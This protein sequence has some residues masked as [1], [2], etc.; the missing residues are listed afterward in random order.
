M[1]LDTP[2]YKIL[3]ADDDVRARECGHT[4]TDLDAR[5]GYVHLSSRD[6]VADTLRLHYAGH[7]GVQLYQF[8]AERLNG[9][10]KW[11]KSRGGDLFPHLYGTLRLSDAEKQWTLD[12]DDHGNPVLP[13]GLR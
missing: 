4:D 9:E 8:S 7:A 6:Q 10:V 12:T 13:E 1:M 3:S 5:D 2:V 11:E